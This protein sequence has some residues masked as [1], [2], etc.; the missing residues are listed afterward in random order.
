MSVSTHLY[1]KVYHPNQESHVRPSEENAWLRPFSKPQQSYEV[2][3][4]NQ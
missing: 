3:S 4:E 2:G 1:L